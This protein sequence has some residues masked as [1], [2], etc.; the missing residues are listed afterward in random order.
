MSGPAVLA[1][2]DGRPRPGSVATATNGRTC[3]YRAYMDR[4]SSRASLISFVQALLNALD[5]AMPPLATAGTEPKNTLGVKYP[6]RPYVAP[7]LREIHHLE[8]VILA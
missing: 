6:C 3:A 8:W 7:T 4:K 1:C 5:V 2:H